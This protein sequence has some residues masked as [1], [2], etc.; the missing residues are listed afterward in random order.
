[1]HGEGSNFVAYSVV[2]SRRSG[3]AVVVLL[4]VHHSFVTEERVVVA[5]W[6]SACDALHTSFGHGGCAV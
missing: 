6:P 4:S 5:L 1:M 2:W 3:Q